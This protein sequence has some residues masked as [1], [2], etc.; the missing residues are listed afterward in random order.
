MNAK[1]YDR[2]LAQLQ[3]SGYRERTCQSY[4]KAVQQL[5]RFCNKPLSKLTQGD[6]RDYWL[7]CR[8]DYGWRPATLRISYSGIKFFFSRTLVRN[9]KLIKEVRFKREQTLPT[10]MSAGEAKR[11]I[12]ALPTLQSKVFYVTLYSLGLR[13]LEAITLEVRDIDGERGVVHVRGGKGARDRTIPLPE[14]T[15]RALRAYYKTHRNKRWIFP[16]IGHNQFH[17]CG[18]ATEPVSKTGVQRVLGRTAERLG[19]TKRVHP[20]VFR[21]SYATHMLEA[22]VPIHHVQKLLGH[23]TLQSTIVYL[24]VTTMAESHSHERVC[25]VIQGALS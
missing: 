19:M 2:M 8:N 11:I 22:N 18:A 6:L 25:Q 9:W 13:L 10:V 12:C 15:R 24:H 3:L 4:L 21:H 5:Q 1:L 16:A 23:K 7:A 14:I 17:K 20:H